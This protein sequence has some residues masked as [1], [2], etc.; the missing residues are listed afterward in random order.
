MSKTPAN[1]LSYTESKPV[2]RAPVRPSVAA[3]RVSFNGNESFAVGERVIATGKPGVVAFVG[4][5]KFAEGV[6]QS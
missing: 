6:I 5:T 4:P 2:F 1:R 3:R